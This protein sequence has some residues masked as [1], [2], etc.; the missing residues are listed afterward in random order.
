MYGSPNSNRAKEVANGIH[1]VRL[2]DESTGNFLH[3]S[4]VG[5]TKDI[6]ESWLGYQRQAQCLQARAEAA[7]HAWPYKTAPR[8]LFETN[9]S[10]GAALKRKS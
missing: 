9:T 6:N 1:M 3:L 10:E 2:Y 7:D 8:D 5:S 4:G